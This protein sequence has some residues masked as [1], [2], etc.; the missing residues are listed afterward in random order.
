[1]TTQPGDSLPCL[2]EARRSGPRGC[3][4]RGVRLQ[5]HV[6][7]LNRAWRHRRSE[8]EHGARRAYIMYIYSA[9]I[10]AGPS[11]DEDRLAQVAW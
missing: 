11:R 6:Q 1:M 8:N 5:R 4:L 3:A 2:A 9:R 7:R 10:M